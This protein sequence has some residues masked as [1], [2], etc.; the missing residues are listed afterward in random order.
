MAL[1]CFNLTMLEEGMTTAPNPDALAHE[2][3]VSEGADPRRR[4]EVLHSVQAMVESTD[5]KYICTINSSDVSDELLEQGWFVAGAMRIVLNM[6]V[7]G[8]PG[9]SSRGD[10]LDRE[11]RGGNAPRELFRQAL[12]GE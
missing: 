2:S 4:A 3:S 11:E 5:G 1:F 10:G 6:E 9:E 7:G 8:L 12:A